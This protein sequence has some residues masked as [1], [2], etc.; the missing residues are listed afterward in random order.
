MLVCTK[1]CEG[2]K[3]CVKENVCSNERER[4]RK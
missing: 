4:E 3:K 2:E 1:G